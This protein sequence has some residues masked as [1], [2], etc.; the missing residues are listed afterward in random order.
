MKI[1]KLNKDGTICQEY[2]D[3]IYKEC[4][5]TLYYR[6]DGIGVTQRRYYSLIELKIPKRINI[7]EEDYFYN[8]EIKPGMGFLYLEFSGGGFLVE[9]K[10]YSSKEDIKPTKIPNVYNELFGEIEPSVALIIC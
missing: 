5:T 7:T 1:L 6:Y 3:K 9:Q 10:I 2:L 4:K 8:K